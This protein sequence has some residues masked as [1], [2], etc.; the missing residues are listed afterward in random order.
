MIDVKHPLR[1]AYYECF[2]G[3]IVFRGLTIPVGDDTV[4]I[5]EDIYIVLAS[6]SGYDNGTFQ[7]FDSVESIDI[8]IVGKAG[9]FANKNVVDAIANQIMNLV[10]PTP[11]VSGLPDQTGIQV[12]C[13]SLKADRYITFA[14]NDS[15]SV[16]RRILTFNQKVRQTLIN[17][18]GDFNNDLSNDFNN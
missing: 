15:N 7:S 10:L 5:D 18:G 17:T 8:D 14:L 1:K 12:N 11:N 9:I 2:N 4:D 3:N 6:Q 16:V 13:I